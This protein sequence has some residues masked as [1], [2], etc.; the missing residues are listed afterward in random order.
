MRVRIRGVAAGEL[1]REGRH[2]RERRMLGC[3]R[4]LDPESFA[5]CRTRGEL[6]DQGE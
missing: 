5:I 4:T 6:A 2:F 1:A 3:E